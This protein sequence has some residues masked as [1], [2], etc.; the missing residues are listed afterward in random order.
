[1]HFHMTYGVDVKRVYKSYSMTYIN[2]CI[3]KSSALSHTIKK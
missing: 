1:M 3:C 2:I